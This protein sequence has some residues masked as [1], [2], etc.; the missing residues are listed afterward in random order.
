MHGPEPGRKIDEFF[1]TLFARELSEQ[2]VSYAEHPPEE[3]LRA[4][5]RGRWRRHQAWATPEGTLARL[6]G[7]GAHEPTSEVWS[8]Q[9]VSLHVLTCRRCRERVL[10]LRARQPL[11]ATLTAPLSWLWRALTAELQETPRPARAAIAL[12]S[13]VIVGLALLLLWQPKAQPQLAPLGGPPPEGELSTHSTALAPT[14][15]GEAGERAPTAP[16]T[17][18]K[19]GLAELPPPALQAIQTL[20]AS[21]DPQARL[22]AIQQLQHYADPRLVEPLTQVYERERHPEVRQAV[23]RTIAQIVKRT[24]SHYAQALRALERLRPLQ[25]LQGQDPA[26]EVLRDINQTLRQFWEDLQNLS[27]RMNYP[28]VL[29]CSA[30]PDLTLA[31]LK[32][33]VRQFEGTVVLEGSAIEPYSFQ[34]RVPAVDAQTS[35]ALEA[36]FR[37]LSIRCR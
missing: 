35:A 7:E 31:Q 10:T 34:V 11:W 36:L 19:E 5:V 2:D 16:L 20:T 23:A 6:Q 1:R 26:L 12:Q 28:H 37:Q 33:L 27:M 24:E 25:G 15:A 21:P 14:A 18:E 29:H 32:D 13:L 3:A 9:E 8:S 17:Q 30:P 4:Y 22:A